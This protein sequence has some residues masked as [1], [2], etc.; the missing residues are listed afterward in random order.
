M[1]I[2]TP[3][4]LMLSV[5]G[6]DYK[7]FFLQVV[8]SCADVKAIAV[9]LGF[10]VPELLLQL[11]VNLLSREQVCMCVIQFCLVVRLSFF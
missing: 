8:H 10:A 11:A 2:A 7:H 5:W 6:V 4:Q 3:L 1:F 9:P